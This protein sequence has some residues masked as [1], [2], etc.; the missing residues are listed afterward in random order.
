MNH[1]KCNTLRPFLRWVTSLERW[2]VSAVHKITK[3]GLIQQLVVAV[4]EE[5]TGVEIKYSSSI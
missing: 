5:V 1:V 4:V 2:L 3:V